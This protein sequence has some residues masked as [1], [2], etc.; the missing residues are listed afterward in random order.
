MLHP[1]PS[2]FATAGMKEDLHMYGNELVTSTSIYTV[3]YV[4]G[5]IPS[6]LL[7]TRISPRWVI[8]AV[9]IPPAYIPSHCVISLTD[10]PQLEVGWGI[11]TICTSSVQS[12]R[13]LYAIRFLVGL[14]EWVYLSFLQSHIA[15]S[16]PDPAST[17]VSTTSSDRGTL[18]VRLA[19][20]LWFSG[21]PAL[22][23][24]YSVDSCNQPLIQT[25]TVCTAMLAGAGYLSSMAL[26]RCHLPLRASCS[27]PISRKTARKRGGR[28]KTSI[29]FLLNAWRLLAVLAR[30][31]GQSPRLSGSSSAG[32]HIFFVRGIL[33]FLLYPNKLTGSSLPIHCVE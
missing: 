20:E 28:Q 9:R 31:P 13:S 8:P 15:D 17:L 18:P 21:L 6:N 26:S 23:E 2:T 14:F 32:I 1:T 27:S 5:Q 19:S 30:S 7:L 11:A 22:L 29:F 3:G 10:S 16:C 33:A 4:I 25:S 12:Y 24:R